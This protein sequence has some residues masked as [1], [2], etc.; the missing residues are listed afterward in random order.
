L[1]NGFYGLPTQELVQWLVEYIDG[2]SA[3][4]IG[5]GSG[6]LGRAMAIPM[7]DNYMQTWPEIKLHYEMN[8]QATIKYGSDVEML[9]AE[10]AISKYNPEVVVASWVTHKYNEKLHH[11][12]GN[13]YSPHED[14]IIKNRTYIVVGNRGTHDKKPILSK[15][16]EE[17]EF[18]WLYSR[19]MNPN[20]VSYVWGV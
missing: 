3:I 12:G 2:R 16:H 1:R 11:L 4:E 7:T 13:M 14:A 10:K 20:N 5:A 6:A 17:Y 8:G 18:D 19:S 15:E 9:D